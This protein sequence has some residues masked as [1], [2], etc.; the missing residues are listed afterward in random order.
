MTIKVQFAFDVIVDSPATK[1]TNAPTTSVGISC[2]TNLI[3]DEARASK[4]DMAVSKYACTTH[5]RVQ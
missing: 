1:V 5:P 3:R 2:S 4:I